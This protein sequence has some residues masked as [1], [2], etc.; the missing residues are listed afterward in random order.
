MADKDKYPE[1]YQ[2]EDNET[3][4][5]DDNVGGEDSSNKSPKNYSPHPFALMLKILANPTL[6]WRNFKS[7]KFAVSD[8][9]K[10]C[11]YPI[12]AV[13]AVA[14]FIRKFYSPDVTLQLLLIDSITKF[15]SYFFGYFIVVMACA[16]LLPKESIKPME[17][18][19]GK[20]YILVGMSSLAF[21]NIFQVVL[22]MLEPIL[23]FLP[24]WTIY[25]LSKGIKYVKVPDDRKNITAGL[26]AFYSIGIT[27]LLEW[28]FRTITPLPN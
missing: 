16:H 7:S 11:F 13:L 25:I 6:G 18:Q 22:P 19:F 9:E 28:L 21:F 20:N 5:Y 15:I 4:V 14:C 27:I 2:L 10:R 17:S 12:L 3:E 24:L 26:V 23:V 1:E 8:V